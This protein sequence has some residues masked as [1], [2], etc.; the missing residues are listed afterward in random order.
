MHFGLISATA[1]VASLGQWKEVRSSRNTTPPR[2]WLIPKSLLVL[3][4]DRSMREDGSAKLMVSVEAN[5]KQFPSG[6]TFRWSKMIVNHEWW[7]QKKKENRGWIEELKFRQKNEGDRRGINNR[8]LPEAITFQTR[9]NCFPLWSKLAQGQTMSNKME[10]TSYVAAETERSY[11][12]LNV[13]GLWTSV[14]PTRGNAIWIWHCSCIW[15]VK[16][17]FKWLVGAQVVVATAAARGFPSLILRSYCVLKE[18][19]KRRVELRKT[20][21]LH[22]KNGKLNFYISATEQT[23]EDTKVKLRETSWWRT[24]PISYL[25]ARQVLFCQMYWIKATSCDK[26]TL[27]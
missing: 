5:R 8:I 25:V 26:F 15:C 27:E 12:T 4:L 6:R 10:N 18:R 7:N 11:R 24:S 3:C 2:R 19:W 1:G 20:Q 23:L 22:W 14:L 17:H 16:L 13:W 9:T 21:G